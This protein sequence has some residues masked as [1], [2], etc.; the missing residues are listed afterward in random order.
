MGDYF[1]PG[2]EK[3]HGSYGAGLRLAMNQNFV[4]SIDYG[5]VMN[6]QDGDSGLYIGMNYLF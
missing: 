4:I 2:A 6:K 1:N 5:R 3:M